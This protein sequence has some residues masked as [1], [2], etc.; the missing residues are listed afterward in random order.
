M[1][2]VIISIVVVIAAGAGIA[3]VFYRRFVQ[4]KHE[5]NMNAS[6]KVRTEQDQSSRAHMSPASPVCGEEVFEEQYHP[7]ANYVDLFGKGI[8]QKVNDADAVNQPQEEDDLSSDRS[9]S[10]GSGNVASH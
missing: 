3:Y 4:A 7:G 5:A 1:V 6:Q 8:I 10:A 9:S 2:A